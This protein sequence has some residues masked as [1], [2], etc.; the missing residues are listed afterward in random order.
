MQ[1]PEMIT[2]KSVN[3]YST[4][5]VL[6]YRL[7][8]G[9]GPRNLDNAAAGCAA[10]TVSDQTIQ[11]GRSATHR[12]ELCAGFQLS[13]EL[14][15]RQSRAREGVSDVRDVASELWEGNAAC[16]QLP[17]ELGGRD[18]DEVGSCADVE[19]GEICDEGF[20]QRWREGV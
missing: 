11:S 6:S 1:V 8:T 4:H 9:A 7:P 15:A 13:D 17:Q 18:E 3:S 16:G 19:R 2:Q 14:I 20:G 5:G 12:R 10:K